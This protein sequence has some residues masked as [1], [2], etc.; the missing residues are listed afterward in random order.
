MLTARIKIGSGSTVNM[1]DTYGLVYLDSDK[2]FWPETKGFES[3]SY[4]EQE[5]ENI[6]PKTVDAPF[7]YK[8]KFFVQSATGELNDINHRIKTF[9]EA[10]Y[11]QAQ[12][13]DVKTFKQ[14][15]FYNDCKRVKIVGYP[16]PISEAIEFW[17]DPSSQVN[18]IAIVEFTIRVNS[19]KLCNF[20]SAS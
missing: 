11:T 5:G 4:V 13:E 20:E 7:D 15:T 8:V 6:L 1:A 14:V 19:P 3:T 16:K 18:D 12:N 2:I 10:L 9:N 17:R